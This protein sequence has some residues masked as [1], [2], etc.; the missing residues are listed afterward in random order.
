MPRRDASE[1]VRAERVQAAPAIRR[2]PAR[3]FPAKT[4]AVRPR[5]IKGRADA[6]ASSSAVASGDEETTKVARKATNTTLLP[7]RV[8]CPSKPA[9]VAGAYATPSRAL[10]LLIRTAL[11]VA[12][13]ITSFNSWAACSS[14]LAKAVIEGSPCVAAVLAA[15]G[16]PFVS[17][18]FLPRRA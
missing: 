12:R 15:E 14:F 17:V 4:T 1:Q 9:L 7:L 16:R 13:V 5:P 10:R 6:D 11:H 3:L 8:S 2:R 18:P